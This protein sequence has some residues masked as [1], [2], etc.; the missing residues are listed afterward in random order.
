MK[1]SFIL[2]IGHKFL[3]GYFRSERENK[4]EKLTKKLETDCTGCSA[5]SFDS[6]ILQGLRIGVKL[7]K[8]VKN[9]LFIHIMSVSLFKINNLLN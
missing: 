9:C 5:E 7:P 4:E 6:K 3:F 1:V 8:S 2:I